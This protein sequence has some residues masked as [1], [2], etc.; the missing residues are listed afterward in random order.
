MITQLLILCLL[1]D[2]VIC[3]R[4]ASKEKLSFWSDNMARF[5]GEN[6]GTVCFIIVKVEI[7]RAKVRYV[8]INY[9]VKLYIFPSIILFL[10]TA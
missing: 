1:I 9:I 6:Q 10:A 5:G 8:Y 4:D 7:Y 3:M 2:W